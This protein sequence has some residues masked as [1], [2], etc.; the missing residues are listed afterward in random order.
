MVSRLTRSIMPFELVCLANI[1]TSIVNPAVRI[2]L[3][4]VIIIGLK[5][6]KRVRNFAT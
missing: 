6:K 2:M 3:S 1:S 5:V 4:K